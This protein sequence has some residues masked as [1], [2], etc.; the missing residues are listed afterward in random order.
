[1]SQLQ[2]T[3]DQQVPLSQ[4]RA[5]YNNI[6]RKAKEKGYV[7]V[8][9]NY[10]PHSIIMDPE[11]FLKHLTDTNN[12]KIDLGERE[13]RAMAVTNLLK[14]R[15]KIASTVKNWHPLQQLLKDRASH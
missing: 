7:L 12:Q 6:A 5:N 8:L 3:I 14:F 13:K 11:F 4:V 10:L 15:E 2:T 9:K 1:M